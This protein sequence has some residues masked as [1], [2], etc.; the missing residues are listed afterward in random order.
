MLV[1]RCASLAPSDS[2]QGQRKKNH[3]QRI[4][5]DGSK[6]STRAWCSRQFHRR[7]AKMAEDFLA[8]PSVS[9]QD[10]PA[11]AGTAMPA[12]S[13]HPYRGRKIVFDL[14]GCNPPNFAWSLLA[15]DGSGSD[16]EA[17]PNRAGAFPVESPRVAGT[18][19]LS[20]ER[21]AKQQPPP[22]AG[23]KSPLARR[24]RLRLRKVL[25]PVDDDEPVR[26][27]APRCTAAATTVATA[28]AAARAAAAAKERVRDGLDGHGPSSFAWDGCAC[29]KAQVREGAAISMEEQQDNE[30]RARMAARASD[31]AEKQHGYAQAGSSEGMAASLDDNEPPRALHQGRKHWPQPRSLVQSALKSSDDNNVMWQHTGLSPPAPPPALPPPPPQPM[32]HAA[33]VAVAQVSTTATATAAHAAPPPPPAYLASPPPALS[34]RVPIAGVRSAEKQDRGR[35]QRRAEEALEQLAV[36]EKEHRRRQQ[37]LAEKHRQ[38]ETEQQMRLQEIEQKIKRM[39]CERLQQQQQMERE[40]V[41][42]QLDA[43]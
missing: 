27:V 30:I 26:R 16:D 13:M 8:W 40:R 39:E 43:E 36:Q 15:D 14:L 29:T 38:L 18:V 22:R 21:A 12:S 17:C 1:L 41:Q 2:P 28:A 35:Q 31:R 19:P 42:R 25:P 32:P 5:T 4:G 9:P 6:I 34:V 24:C 33:G 10:A 7:F 37:E 11:A 23:K 3:L 20:P